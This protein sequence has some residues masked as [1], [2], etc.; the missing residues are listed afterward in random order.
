MFYFKSNKHLS[1]LN[2]INSAPKDAVLGVHELALSSLAPEPSPWR[3]LAASTRYQEARMATAC[4]TVAIFLCEI[5][6][7]FSVI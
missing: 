4:Q 2:H 1:I 5:G 3:P 6:L 7:N